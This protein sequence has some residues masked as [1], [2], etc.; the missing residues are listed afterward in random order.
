[1]TPIWTDPGPRR[2]MRASTGDS[3]VVGKLSL[4]HRHFHVPPPAAAL[5]FFLCIQTLA[6]RDG[7]HT[8]CVILAVSDRTNTMWWAYL[9]FR[10]YRAV[11]RR[12]IRTVPCQTP[13][14]CAMRSRM[15]TEG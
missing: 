3:Y 7:A 1:M 4:G 12:S 11:E 8:W 13:S 10:P 5:G 14:S 15:P 9:V 2:P 6:G